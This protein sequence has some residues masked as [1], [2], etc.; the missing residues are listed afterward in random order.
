MTVTKLPPKC[1]AE[2]ELRILS[3]LKRIENAQREL[4]EA[5]SDLSPVIGM[6]KPWED[7]GKLGE[8]VKAFWH[9]LNGKFLAGRGSWNMDK[10]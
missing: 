3:A 8:K 4:Y 9:R 7:A 5:C 10:D 2:A 1:A 6:V